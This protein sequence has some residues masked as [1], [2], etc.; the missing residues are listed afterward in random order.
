MSQL[1][2]ANLAAAVALG[3]RVAE[4]YSLIY[5]RDACSPDTLLPAP[6]PVSAFAAPNIPKG[7]ARPNAPSVASAA[8]RE[9]LSCRPSEVDS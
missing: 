1:E 9:G 2:N 7:A 8:R 5:D 4:L 6:I 3:W